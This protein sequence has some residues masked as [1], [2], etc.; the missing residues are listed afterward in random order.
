MASPESVATASAND[1]VF[2]DQ[3]P[4]A[5]APAKTTQALALP[6]RIVLECANGGT[7]AAVATKLGGNQSTMVGRSFGEVTAED[8]TRR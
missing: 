1:S 8:P 5:D 6:A 4:E 7:N 3:T 2:A